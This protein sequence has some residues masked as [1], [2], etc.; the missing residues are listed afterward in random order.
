M[1]GAQ[2]ERLGVGPG[3]RV[4]QFASSSFDAMVWELCMAL[5]SGATLVL[6]P[7]ERVLPGPSLTRLVEEHRVTHAT[8]PPSALGALAA[9][10]G[11][12]AGVTLV[13]AGEPCP[14]D[15][16]GHWSTGRR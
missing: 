3:S 1:V 5:L 16:V 11:L 14:A 6:G 15:L 10:S 4:L 7:A 12:P 2:V 13:T 8:L 9:G